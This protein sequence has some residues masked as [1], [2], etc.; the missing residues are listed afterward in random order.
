VA[1]ISRGKS[2]WICGMYYSWNRMNV[3]VS[4]L[5]RGSPQLVFDAFY[6]KYIDKRL[7]VIRIMC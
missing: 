6:Y 1:A 7:L 2:V 4:V 3:G 5:L